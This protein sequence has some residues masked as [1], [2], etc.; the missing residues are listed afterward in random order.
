MVRKL[1][2]HDGSIDMTTAKWIIGIAFLLFGSYIAAMNWAVFINNHILKKKWTSAVPL[3]GGIT[4]GIGIACLPI[5]GIWRYAWIP[6]LI[7]WGSV[8]VIAVSLAC[9]LKDRGQGTKKTDE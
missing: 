2:N 8:P 4:A 9:H 5:F 6:L 7:D 3:V 1:T